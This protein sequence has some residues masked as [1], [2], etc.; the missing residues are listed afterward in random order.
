MS[1]F[2]E[3]LRKDFEE[4]I[5]IIEWAEI[6]LDNV[7]NWEEFEK[8][9]DDF[10]YYE[11]GVYSDCLEKAFSCEE[12]AKDWLLDY[13]ADTRQSDDPEEFAEDFYFEEI[14]P[15]VE[16]W[17]T[18]LSEDITKE[19]LQALEKFFAFY[20]KETGKVK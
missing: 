6:D 4:A 3:T 8:A 16:N 18:E 14:G 20:E 19:E 10:H 11:S 17:E 9:I 13:H 1:N 12:E 7:N 5:N 2:I 15:F